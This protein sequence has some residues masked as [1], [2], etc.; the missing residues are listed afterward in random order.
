LGQ[1]QTTPKEPSHVRLRDIYC[2]KT[3]LITG[4]TGFKGSWLSQW[5]LMLGAKVYGYSLSPPTSPALFDQLG[6]GEGVFDR[7]A[8]IRHFDEF[9]GYVREVKPEIIFHLAAQSLVRESYDRPL[10]T[11][12]VN[13]L[14]SACVLEAV[15]QA[16]R[17]LVAIMVTS[18]KCYSN[19][20]WV[21]GYRE[22]DPMGGFDVYSA[23]KGAAELLIDSWRMSFFPSASLATH[24][25]RVASVRAGNVI[26]GGD[27]AKDRIVPDCVR[28]LSK[29]KPVNVRN[30]LATRPWQHVLDPLSGYL[31]LGALLLDE[32]IPLERKAIYCSG[33]NFGPTISSNRSTKVLV[34]RI[35]K[36]WGAGS[37]EDKSD[38]DA[39]HEAHLLQLS[40]DKAY[41]LLHWQP[42]WDLD[43]AVE[44][45]VEWYRKTLADPDCTK[46]VT[47][48]Q[49][50][51]Y[52]ADN[53]DRKND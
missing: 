50:A 44:R 49:I 25:T 7:R 21:F 3:V 31:E 52:E 16:G 47:M 14:G 41:H 38:P 2:N 15:R 24:G 29:G 27:W 4:H 46:Q 40:I 33:F 5:L 45:T 43:L 36:S 19:Q 17:P 35:I 51:A 11:A 6:L 34:E 18:D 12:E 9:L 28:A 20:E 37:W 26:G 53:L 30:P 8:D 13:T 1:I 10:E 22:D 39:A 32:D 48:D 23:S 42:T